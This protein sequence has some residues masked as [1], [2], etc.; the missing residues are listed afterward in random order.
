MA[1]TTAGADGA[2]KARAEANDALL[3][4]VPAQEQDVPAQDSDATQDSD[5]AQDSDAEQ[6]QLSPSL[7][8]EYTEP[9][10]ILGRPM[11][12]AEIAE[13]E[14]I[15]SEHTQHLKPID[16]GI[17]TALIG[18]VAVTCESTDDA[19]SLLNPDEAEAQT[20]PFGSVTENVPTAVNSANSYTSPSYT[21]ADGRQGTA[22]KAT[23]DCEADPRAKK[24]TDDEP[25][26]H[27]KATAQV[28]SL[29]PKDPSGAPDTAYILADDVLVG[30]TT[31]SRYSLRDEGLV[32]APKNQGDLGAC[33][34]FAS[35]AASES[36]LLLTYPVLRASHPDFSEMHLAYA[37]Y[38]KSIDPLGGFTDDNTLTDQ[39]EGYL[40]RGG[41]ASYAMNV[42]AGWMGYG[43][44]STY[45]YTDKRGASYV[46]DNLKSG[47]TIA[48]SDS[49]Y[50]LNGSIVTGMANSDIVK[51]YIRQY[52][53]AVVMMYFSE[54]NRNYNPQTAA[55]FYNGSEACN[56]GVTLVG[57]DDDY[58]PSNFSPVVP[59][60]A[61]AWIVKNSWGT[62]WGDGGYF[63]ISYEDTV[64]KLSNAS[65]FLAGANEYDNNYQYDA[66][67]SSGVFSVS[68]GTVRHA[69]VF[70]IKSDEVLSA[71]S[72]YATPNTSYQIKVFKLAGS[73]SSITDPEQGEVVATGSGSTTFEGWKLVKLSPGVAAAPGDNYS[74][75]VTLSSTNGSSSTAIPVEYSYNSIVTR[76]R[77]QNF[78]DTGRGWADA[79]DFLA[80]DSVGNLRV[81]LLTGDAAVENPITSITL[82]PGTLNLGRCETA[83]ISAQTVLAGGG[84]TTDRVIFSSSDNTIASVESDGTVTA[85]MPG[86]VTITAYAKS[87]PTVCATCTVTVAIKTPATSVEATD[88]E[89]TVTKGKEARAAISVLP[90]SSDDYLTWTADKSGIVSIVSYDNS[91]ITVRGLSLGT[92]VLTGTTTSGRTCSITVTVENPLEM[93][94]T[95]AVAYD[96]L[97]KTL[98][99]LTEYMVDIRNSKKF[100]KY[101][102]TATSVRYTPSLSTVTVTPLGN[103]GLSGF[104][105]SI[106]DVTSTKKSGDKLKFTATITYIKTSGSK[107]VTKT[108]K[109][110]LSAGIVR[111]CTSLTVKD[112]LTTISSVKKNSKQTIEAVFNGGI[113]TPSDTKLKYLVVDASGT[114]SAEAKRVISV[115]GKGEVKFKGPGT[116]YVKICL[117]SSYDKKSKTYG[118]S[119]LVKAVCPVVSSVGFS[120][121]T[122]VEVKAGASL[123]LKPFL[124]FSPSTPFGAD[125]MKLK[126]TVDDKTLGS[127]SGKGLLK[128]KKKVT[129]AITVTVQAVGGV[130]KG[131]AAPEGRIRLTIVD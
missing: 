93:K 113:S 94:E 33:W 122:P 28:R 102:D 21:S 124:V 42:L 34:A 123:N 82:S 121:D 67:S 37:T 107:S 76:E 84:S 14:R 104:K 114:P 23:A 43:L 73:R 129:G 103:N 98:D 3:L 120:E 66:A 35:I 6:D 91:Y 41:N 27:V 54:G 62:N 109:V 40:D 90:A 70:T 128:V 36:N 64:L 50:R 39:S 116:A 15:T 88:P 47:G 11:T 118:K 78:I 87:S 52:G 32:T 75:V 19:M 105:L 112:G 46:P 8:D 119:C 51:Q 53:A 80:G 2:L 77:K 86:T 99:C 106:S 16:T 83:K 125:N 69:T 95:L 7:T 59:K 31:G 58:S 1:G 30:G 5:A 20:I 49:G 26:S 4:D 127:V 38:Q 79:C 130:P 44:E 57:W 111:P 72:L 100:S 85:R 22:L 61:G 65:F 115:S 25:N 68:S 12:D 29:S 9:D 71:V 108:K 74:V 18:D 45:P 126:W 48:N 10:Y 97:P 131:A 60:S 89:L 24:V 63:Y 55:Y 56:H 96:E 117:A 81:K 92:T 110:M 17:T 13:Q 101:L